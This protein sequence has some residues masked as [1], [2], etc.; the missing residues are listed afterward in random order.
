MNENSPAMV[1]AITSDSASSRTEGNTIRF[2]ECIG[3]P[4]MGIKCSGANLA[5]LTVPEL[6][7]WVNKWRKVFKLSVAQCAKAWDQPE[8]TVSRFVS[9]DEPDFRYSTI[10]GIINGIVRYGCSAEQQRIYISCPATS[11]QIEEQLSAISQLLAQK[12]EECAELTVRKL[13]RA[14]EFA[15]R[16][17]EQRE[18]PEK[19][20]SEKTETIEF[21]RG[22]VQK[23]QKDLEKSEAISKNYL[24]RIDAKNALIN[25]LNGEIRR[26]NAE[27]LRQASNYAADTRATVD[28]VIQIAEDHAADFRMMHFGAKA[29]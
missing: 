13:E 3:C 19:H 22:L 9:G 29:D 20:M 21:L 28:R 14:N 12:T 18:N 15:E 7:I 24:D 16:M 11:A 23:L 10:H 5:L 27:A 6:R 17:A 25:D 8:G 2:E 1:S 26:L 4:D